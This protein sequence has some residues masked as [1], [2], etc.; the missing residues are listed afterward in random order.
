M[1]RNLQ[2]V[3]PSAIDSLVQSGYAGAF[4]KDGFGALPCVPE[5]DSE[6]LTGLRLAVKDVFSIQGLRAGAGN[7]EW[8]KGQL[9]STYTASA[10][11]ALLRAGARWLGK[12]VT[13]ELAF[14]LACN[15]IHYGTP[16]N[17]LAPTRIPGGSS[18]GSA[19][20]VA[21]AYADIG[22]ATDCGGSARLPGSYCGV[23]G[24]RPSHGLVGG[25]SGFPLAPSFDTVG[26]FSRTGD[27]MQRVLEVL[28]PHAQSTRDFG[29]CASRD[30]LD[31]CDPRVQVAYE[32]LILQLE[33]Y[34]RVT[35]CAAD[36]LALRS[37][38]TA[39]RILQGAEIWS[40][41]GE[42]VRVKGHALAPSIRERFESISKIKTD[43]I[44]PAET[45]REGARGTLAELFDRCGILVVPTAPGT[46]PLLTAAEEELTAARERS[47]ML[48]A[49]AGLAGLPQVTLPWISLDGAPVGI[50]LIGPR[51]QDKSVVAAARKLE[52]IM[53]KSEVLESTKTGN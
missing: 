12:T 7:P 24:I 27:V 5:C 2:S 18:S 49:P 33:K 38:A 3:P 17:P 22:L 44:L 6:Q 9:E 32:Q 34:T 16:E 30:V 40:Q 36:T 14:S 37:W 52:E 31:V 21:G 15:N 26:W 19:V 4:V 8:R 1:S 11:N 20:A 29:W 50:S 23:W 10:V 13:D 35:W 46:A 47:H 53:S 43:Q 28:A 51:G 25:V 41:H 48:L 42:W 45:T 39:H